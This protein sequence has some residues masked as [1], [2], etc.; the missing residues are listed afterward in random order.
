MILYECYKGTTTIG[1]GSCVGDFSCYMAKDG[2]NQIASR[3]RALSNIAHLPVV[4]ILAKIGSGSCTG[5]SIKSYD[6]A[7]GPYYGF[8]C[9]YFQGG[10]QF[11]LITA[12]A[13]MC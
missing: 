8:S 9:A 4:F 12:I 7:A 6:G 5:D 2:K 13:C 3:G 11:L 1:K 10:L